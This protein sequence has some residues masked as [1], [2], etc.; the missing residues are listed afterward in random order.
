M[1]RHRFLAGLGIAAA[2]GIAC[3]RC[4]AADEIELP[5][6][7]Y[8]QSTPEN[9][10]SKLIAE[11]GSGDARLDYDERTGYLPALL[12]ALGVPVESQML[13]FSKTSL[14]RHR[15]SPRS[16]RAVY[17]S[18]DVYIG[19][20]QAG[21]VLEISAVDPQL[22][23]VFYTLDQ[24]QPDEVR[25]LRQTE[26]CLV[27][28]SSSRTGGIPG[29]VI[30]SLFVDSSGQPILSAGSRTVDHTTPFE[31]RWGGWYVT[32][33]HGSQQHLGN[34]IIKGANVVEPV[35][36]AQG[37]NVTRL[38]GRVSTEKYLTPHSDLVALMILEHQAFVHNHIAKANYAARQALHYEKEMNRVLGEPQE[39]RLES[40]TRRIQGAGD[41]LVEAL[42]MA[43][44][45]KLSAPVTGTSGYAEKFSTLG[46][47]D[48]QG[49]SL[50]QL[51]LN[52]RLFKYPCSYLIDSP[53]FDALPNEMRDYVWK[54]LWSV[55]TEPNIEKQFAHLSPDDRRAIVEIVAETKQNIPDYWTKN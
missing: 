13:V 9:C 24:K 48:R 27:C 5:P 3:S 14:Q 34:L 10:V 43:G 1:Q 41:D 33:T 22:G 40:T 52:R 20:C 7:Q 30:R 18:D 42:L 55:L 21:D 8:S 46:H 29:H 19:Y 54:R 26:N 11:L 16:P 32:G 2:L 39:H 31:H 38:E 51:D 12:K 36:N 4:E 49:R 53:A 17:F 45:A 37:Q 35:D 44:E 6:I 47:R 25:L 23:A 50:R 15:I 28:H